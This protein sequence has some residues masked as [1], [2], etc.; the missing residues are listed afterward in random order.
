MVGTVTMGSRSSGASRVRGWSEQVLIGSPSPPL[1]PPV[2]S[3]HTV[4]TVSMA[5]V[6]VRRQWQWPWHGMGMGTG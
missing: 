1:T 5:F 6:I 2:D 3:P 4:S